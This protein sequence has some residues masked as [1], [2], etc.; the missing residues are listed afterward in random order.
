MFLLTRVGEKP[1]RKQG[2]M[3]PSTGRGALAFES[4]TDPSLAEELRAT[5]SCSVVLLS[6]DSYEEARRV[7]NRAVPHRPALIALCESATDV[8]AAV[9][10]AQRHNLPLSV[11]GG[12]H[13]WA[14]RAL[15][16]DGLVID[17]TRLREVIVDPEAR[18]ATVAGGARIKDVA[19]AA[20]AHGLVAALGNCGA[21]GIGGFTLGGGYGPLSGQ[22]GLAADNLLGAEIVLADGRRVLTNPDQEPELFWALRGGGGNFGVVTSLRIQLH[23]KRHLLAGSI[24]YPWSDAKNVLSRYAVFMATA[25]DELGTL[26]GMASGPDGQLAVQLRP[27]WN[28]EAQQGERVLGDLQALGTPLLTQLGPMS[29]SDMI[30]PGDAM[31]EQKDSCHWGTRTRW[32]SAL[33]PG[34]IDVMIA[35]VASKTSP[36]SI[37][38]MDPLHGAGDHPGLGAG[39]GRRLDA[40][41]VGAGPLAKPRSVCSAGRLCQPAGAG[42]SRTGGGCLRRQR[43]PAESPQASF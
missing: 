39:R 1:E 13:D 11:R 15:C 23:E 28:G 37:V 19:A 30:A 22:Y 31:L 7:W 2:I 18:V 8:Q 26:V 29:Y 38:L 33:T 20:D 41:A 36:H 16:D 35:A 14:G 34:A 42:R 27:L 17:L 21:V 4:P 9:R 24:L 40:S 10:L 3:E 32:L 12:G 25:P 43:C 6:D 5:V